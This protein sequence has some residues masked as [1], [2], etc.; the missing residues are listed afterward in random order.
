[1]MKWLL[2]MPR[3]SLRVP[4]CTNASGPASEYLTV[5]SVGRFVVHAIMMRPRRSPGS[6]GMCQ[7]LM[8]SITNSGTSG[9]SASKHTLWKRSRALFSAVRTWMDCPFFTATGALV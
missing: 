6:S 4:F 5:P 8:F 3:S 9:L 2:T 7:A 1:M